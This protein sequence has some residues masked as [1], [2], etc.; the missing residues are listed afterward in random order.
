[1]G[2]P[3]LSA[4]AVLA[5][6]LRVWARHLAPTLV[7]TLVLLLPGYLVRYLSV[8]AAEPGE[9]VG[10]TLLQAL[11]D[12]VLIGLATGAIGYG[13]FQDLAGAPVGLG[14][15]VVVGLQR[16]APVALVSI[17]TGFVVALGYL[18]FIL[19]GIYLSTVLFVAVPV[20]L[21]EGR[22]TLDAMQRSAELTAGQRRPIILI[23][24]L[25]L[26]LTL[27]AAAVLVELTG[28]EGPMFWTAS[29]ATATMLT[30]F[31]AV[32]SAVVYHDLRGCKEGLSGEALARVFE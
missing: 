5:T 23:A 10:P 3:P 9:S 21:V 29:L 13:V 15:A 1:V 6:S 16:L 24:G 28:G 26:A 32:T 4:G 27:G 18:A 2:V 12:Q 25:L 30:S 31:T 11:L 22:G 8:T 19:P 20:A 17:A 7:L 14:R